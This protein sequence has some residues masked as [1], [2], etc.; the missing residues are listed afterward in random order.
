MLYSLIQTAKAN[1]LEPNAYLRYVFT[2]PPK[3][4]TLE[5]IEAL[6]PGHINKDQICRF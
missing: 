1:G 4:E 5:S 3:Q 2:E 6:L